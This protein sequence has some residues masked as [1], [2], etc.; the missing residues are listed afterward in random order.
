MN[1]KISVKGKNLIK[2]F[3]ALKLKAY[4]CPAGVLTIGWGHTGADVKPGMVITLA[5]AERLLDADLKL[6]EEG[7]NKLV[8]AYIS[9]NQFDALVSFAFN[10]GLDI[11][12]DSIAEGLGDSTLLKLVNANPGDVRIKAEFKKWNKAKGVVLPGLTR[13]RE[14]E[15]NLYFS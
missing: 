5:E 11:D 10:I 8:K 7:V 9:Q 14:A 4:L 3:E 12:A 13:R 2:S 1:H 15:L 6:F